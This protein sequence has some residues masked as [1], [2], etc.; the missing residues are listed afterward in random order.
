MFDFLKMAEKIKEAKAQMEATQAR[1]AAETF[2]GEAGGGMVKVHVQGDRKLIS[3]EIDPDLLAKKE[4]ETL[5]DL[6]VA[7][8]N[9]ALA[10]AE[11]AMQ[12]LMKEQGAGF[13]SQIPGLDL[14]KLF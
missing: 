1:L 14:S 2:T 5:Q 4:Q 8:T 10:S 3:V 6:I 11:E 9:I 13:L 12:R 7:A